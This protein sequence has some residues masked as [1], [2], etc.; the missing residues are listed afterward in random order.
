ME[1]DIGKNRY[2]FQISDEQANILYGVVSELQT[3]KGSPPT[4]Q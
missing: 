2:R 1:D 3:K 4:W